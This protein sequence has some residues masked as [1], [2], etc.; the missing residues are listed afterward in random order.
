MSRTREWWLCYRKH[1]RS[2]CQQPLDLGNGIKVAA[3]DLPFRSISVSE[4]I[5]ID[6]MKDQLY[7]RLVEQS[8]LNMQVTSF[9]LS[10]SQLSAEQTRSNYNYILAD[11]CGFRH[12]RKIYKNLFTVE[13]VESS[14]QQSEKRRF[15]LRVFFKSV[16]QWRHKI[17]CEGLECIKNGLELSHALVSSFLRLIYSCKRNY[18]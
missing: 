16:S 10:F 5:K 7:F 14:S 17:E 6:G 18:V 8:I 3:F 15:R 9:C 2:R 11:D 1:K 13:T 4:T 12:L